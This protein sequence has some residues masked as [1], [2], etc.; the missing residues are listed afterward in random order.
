M[1]YHK[2]V[3]EIMVDLGDHTTFDDDKSPTK[4]VVHLHI[5]LEMWLGDDLLE[6]HPVILLL[7]DSEMH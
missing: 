7:R 3:P 6:N 1:E 2:I 4:N 5:N